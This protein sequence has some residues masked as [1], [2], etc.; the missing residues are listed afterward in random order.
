[1]TVDAPN[2]PIYCHKSILRIKCLYF[3]KMFREPWNE[4]DK[5]VIEV[6]NYSYAVYHA[7]LKYLYTEQV[8]SHPFF[9]P[10]FLI[11]FHSI[12]IFSPFSYYSLLFFMFFKKKLKFFFSKFFSKFFFQNFFFKIFSQNFFSTFFYFL[13]L[14]IIILLS[15]VIYSDDNSFFCLSIFYSSYTFFCLRSC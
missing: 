6:E 8:S 11:T 12:F 15:W 4:V 3:Q 10:L 5:N 13:L 1:M 2:R 9:S 14:C 7:F